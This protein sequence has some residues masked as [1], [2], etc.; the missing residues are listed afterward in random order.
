MADSADTGL[1]FRIR[2]LPRQDSEPLLTEPEPPPV[3]P[4]PEPTG[5][6]SHTGGL[7]RSAQAVLAF[8][9]AVAGAR[10]SDEAHAWRGPNQQWWAEVMVPWQHAGALVANASGVAYAGKPR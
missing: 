6:L 10:L 7:F 2:S 5:R 3:A 9:G 8:L 4:I 1:G